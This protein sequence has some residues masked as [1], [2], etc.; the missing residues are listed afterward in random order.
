MSEITDIVL[1][2][3]QKLQAEISAIRASLNE[4]RVTQLEQAEKLDDLNGYVTGALGYIGRHEIDLVEMKR[5][6]KELATERSPTPPR[7]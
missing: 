6:M 7:S 3:L 4:V 5:A 2:V 1:P